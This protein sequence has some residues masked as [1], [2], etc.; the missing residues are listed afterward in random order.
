MLDGEVMSAPG[1]SSRSRPPP[2]SADLHPAYRDRARE[3]AQ[4]RRPPVG[5][6]T[7]GIRT[8]SAQ[9]GYQYLRAGLIAGGIGLP[10]VIIY[11]LPYYRL[12]GVITILSLVLSGAL[13]YAM[14]VLLGRWIG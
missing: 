9:L 11:C 12:L 2:R 13:I 10:L 4:V 1:I 7:A 5:L 6:R 14:M 8:V 3:L